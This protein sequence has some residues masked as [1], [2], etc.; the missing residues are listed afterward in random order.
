MR[1]VDQERI[2]YKIKRK[3]EGDMETQKEQKESERTVMY[4]EKEKVLIQELL[5]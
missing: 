4:E 5:I 3:I 1:R 2:N